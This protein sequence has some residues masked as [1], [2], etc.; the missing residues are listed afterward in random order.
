MMPL[1]L[2]VWREQHPVGNEQLAIDLTA[3]EPKLA[4]VR[5]AVGFREKDE[6]GSGLPLVT[7]MLTRVANSD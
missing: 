1:L 5:S 4:R 3:G 7:A 6:S 2:K